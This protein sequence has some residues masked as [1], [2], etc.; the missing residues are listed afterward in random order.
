MVEAHDRRTKGD[1]AVP[2]GSR[3]RSSA[4]RPRSAIVILSL[5]AGHRLGGWSVVE[6]LP[7]K[8]AASSRTLRGADGEVEDPR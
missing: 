4:G 5:I 7:L 8:R 3:P 2:L 1:R 6:V